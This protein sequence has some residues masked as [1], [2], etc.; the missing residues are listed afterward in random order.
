MLKPHSY[1]RTSWFTRCYSSPRAICPQQPRG[2]VLTLIR[3]MWRDVCWWE[4]LPLVCSTVKAIQMYV[5]FRG[6]YVSAPIEANLNILSSLLDCGHFKSHSG[7][8]L[9]IFPISVMSSVNAAQVGVGCVFWWQEMYVWH[10][11]IP[12]AD[13]DLVWQNM[14]ISNYLRY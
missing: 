3:V 6:P 4:V 9:Y 8:F 14:T 5:I 10:V 7:F 2:V 1:G 11:R 13:D 12:P